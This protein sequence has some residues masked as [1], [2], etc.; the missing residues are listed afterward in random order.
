MSDNSPERLSH[1]IAG[2]RA[3]LIQRINQ[4]QN[5]ISEL[6]DGVAVNFRADERIERARAESDR[7]AAANRAEHDRGLAKQV[8]T[9]A[10]QIVHL[11]ARVAA[12]ERKELMRS[13]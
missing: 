3:D 7:G 9:L 10:Q 8:A 11:N 5:A 6:R 1:Q 13:H 2:I 12:M 4:L